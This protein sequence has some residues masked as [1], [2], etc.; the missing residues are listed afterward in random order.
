MQSFLENIQR[1]KGTWIEMSPYLKDIYHRLAL[2]E[3]RL[4]II[5]K[6]G[7]YQRLRISYAN[8]DNKE[9][10]YGII[11]LDERELLADKLT[12]EELKDRHLQRE[13]EVLRE[14]RENNA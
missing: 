11:M 1:N 9:Q 3:D 13:V 8:E 2:G 10:F 5:R 7:I 14:T 12:Y 4:H 6:N